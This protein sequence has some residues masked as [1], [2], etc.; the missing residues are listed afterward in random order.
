MYTRVPAMAAILPHTHNSIDIPTL[1]VFWMT[2][3]GVTKIPVPVDFN[4]VSA[5]AE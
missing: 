4:L 5:P 1:C 2:V 3:V